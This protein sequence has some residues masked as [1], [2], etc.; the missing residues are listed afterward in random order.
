LTHDER[1]RA[2]RLVGVGTAF[3]GVLLIIG[4]D[5][6]RGLGIRLGGELAVLGATWSY[7]LAGVFARRFFTRDFRRIGVN[8]LVAAA[9]QMSGATLIIAPFALAVEHPWTV[10]VPTWETGAAILGM[11]LLSTALA[12]ILYFRIL[13]SAG[14]TNSMLVTLLMPVTAILLGVIIL[15]ERL[16]PRHYVGFALLAAGLVA[17]DGRIMSA[18]PRIPRST[19]DRARPPMRDAD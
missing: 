17:V 11:S 5:A 8:P 10:S 3:L 1:I 14:A 7:A 16:D 6:L 12:S 9:G 18:R 13:A 19:T 2:N 15:G 4:V